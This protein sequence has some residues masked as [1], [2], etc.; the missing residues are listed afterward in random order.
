MT[1]LL[2]Y[3]I[4]IKVF[5]FITT[6]RFYPLCC[7]VLSCIPSFSLVVLFQRIDKICKLF[8]PSIPPH[9]SILSLHI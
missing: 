4:L 5:N 9:M 8:V 6:F 7:R 1:L 3:F 2:F